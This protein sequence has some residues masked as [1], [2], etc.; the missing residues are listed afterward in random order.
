[1]CSFYRVFS[2]NLEEF[3]ATIGIVLL[4]FSW[5]MEA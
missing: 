2:V 4:I 5:L 3:I 1:V